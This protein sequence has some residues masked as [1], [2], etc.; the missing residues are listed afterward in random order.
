MLSHS[1]VITKT[2][3]SSTHS[4][5]FHTYGLFFWLAY[6]EIC[7]DYWECYFAPNPGLCVQSW[8]IPSRCCIQNMLFQQCSMAI[9]LVL[10]E[11]KYSTQNTPNKIWQKIQVHYFW[12][13]LYNL[14]CL[15]RASPSRVS[16]TAALLPQPP[17]APYQFYQ[18]LYLQH[19]RVLNT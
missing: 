17:T 1:Q 5:Y 6:Q 13:P 18:P 19:C 2:K 16:Q 7:A 11:S 3:W 4:E 12:Q 8:S 15:P 10:H 9:Y 14:T